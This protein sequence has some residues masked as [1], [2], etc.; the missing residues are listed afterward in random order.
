[1]T[2]SGYSFD[3]AYI[4][5]QVKGHQEV[6]ALFEKET[7]DGKEARLKNYAEKLL[8]HIRMHLTRADS[9]R[10]VLENNVKG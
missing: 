7:N 5:S 10:K 3:T 2:L 4:N 6:A 9:I 1:M 8:P